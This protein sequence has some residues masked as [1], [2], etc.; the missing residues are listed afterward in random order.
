[1]A[2][3]EQASRTLTREELYELV[4]SKPMVEVAQDFG[5]SD[6]GL[7]KRCRRLSIPVPGRGY[8]ARV[9]AGQKPARS[10]LPERKVI[11]YW[12][13]EAL[14]MPARREGVAESEFHDAIRDLESLSSLRARASTLSITAAESVLDCGAA[15][16]RTARQLRHPRRAE[17]VFER[18][19]RAGPLVSMDVSVGALDRA[20]LLADRIL[21]ASESLGWRFVD[22]PKQVPEPRPERGRYGGPDVRQP[23]IRAARFGELHVAGEPVGLHIEERM[24]EESRK[25]SAAELA[26]ERREYGYRAPRKTRVPTG[27]LRVVRQDTY[28]KYGTPSRVT[29]YDRGGARVDDQLPAILGGFYELALSIKTRRADHER[30]KRERGEAERRRKELEA[31]Q[32]TNA[33]LVRQLETDAGAWHRARY[34]RRYTAAARRAL[35]MGTIP[36][37]FQKRQINYLAWAERYVDQLDPLKSVPRSTEF[38][39]RTGHYM[40]DLERMKDAFGRLLGSEW[41]HAWKLGADYSHDSESRYYYERSV[42]EVESADEADEE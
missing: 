10:K 23:P 22:A 2:D 31:R 26:R 13:R 8:W 14:T 29:W 35:D 21:K 27:N 34:L 7:A 9:E 39:K 5:I 12:D 25:P 11:A 20:C 28:P 41:A 3:E 38:A 19:S 17:F 33:A 36:V 16:K 32:E 42:F 37:R 24:R 18:G 4:W 6:V 15:V 30:E 40:N 1:M